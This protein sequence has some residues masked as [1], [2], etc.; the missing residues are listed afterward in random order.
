MV[1]KCS[2][3]KR[4]GL[5]YLLQEDRF[6]NRILEGWFRYLILEYSSVPQPTLKYQ[7]PDTGGLDQV[8][9]IR[10]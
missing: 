7:V 6:R 3:F 10:G 5:K 8:P 2:R 1:R 9:D 4:S